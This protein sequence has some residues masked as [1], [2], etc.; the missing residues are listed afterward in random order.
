[1]ISPV[2][3]EIDYR[4]KWSPQNGEKITHDIEITWTGERI[5]KKKG[6]F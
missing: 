2:G 6:G 4:G 1:M 5:E 3:E